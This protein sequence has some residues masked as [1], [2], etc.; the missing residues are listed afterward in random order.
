MKISTPKTVTGYFYSASGKKL[1]EKELDPN[2]L[3]KLVVLP[4]VGVCG[5]YR[6]CYKPVTY[7]YKKKSPTTYIMVSVKLVRTRK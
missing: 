1:F 3:G 6:E 2:L 4:I 5:I 7:W